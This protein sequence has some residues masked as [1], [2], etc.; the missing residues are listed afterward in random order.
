[1]V[2]EGIVP[3][4]LAFQVLSFILLLAFVVG[5]I[6]FIVWVVRQIS[7]S[8]GSSATQAPRGNAEQILQE[9]YARGEITREQ[10]LQMLEDLKR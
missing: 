10:Y 9:R 3:A 2:L 1:M 8:S 6:V 4:Q 7:R 5:F